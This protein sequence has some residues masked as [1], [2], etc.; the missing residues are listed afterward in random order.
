MK[1][2]LKSYSF[3]MSVCAAVILVVNNIGEVF[4]FKIDSEITTKIVDSICGVLILFGIISISKKPS[5]EKP[6]ETNTDDDNSK[7]NE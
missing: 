1:N 3:W 7:Q 5:D 2:K 4:G 6:E